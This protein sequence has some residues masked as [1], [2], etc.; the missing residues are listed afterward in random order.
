MTSSIRGN[1][2]SFGIYRYVER[3]IRKHEASSFALRSDLTSLLSGSVVTADVSCCGIRNQNF[4]APGSDGRY[5]GRLATFSRS[6]PSLTD[7]C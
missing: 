5:C 2:H 1:N 4:P 6:K 3:S 7:A